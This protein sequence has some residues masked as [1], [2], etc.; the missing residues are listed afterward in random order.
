MDRFRAR[1]S[2]F[3]KTPPIVFCPADIVQV[4]RV[5]EHDYHRRS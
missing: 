4:A 1:L 5:L 2:D 3:L